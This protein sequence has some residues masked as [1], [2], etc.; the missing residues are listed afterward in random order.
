[1]KNQ[2]IAENAREFHEMLD[3]YESK[4]YD[5][6]LGLQAKEIFMSQVED[7]ILAQREENYDIPS[8]ANIRYFD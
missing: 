6:R 2:I 4:I 8:R 7:K 5:L 3:S 1:M